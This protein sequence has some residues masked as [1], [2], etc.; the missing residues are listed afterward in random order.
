MSSSRQREAAFNAL[1]VPNSDPSYVVPDTRADERRPDNGRRV[2][3]CC[4][5]PSSATRRSRRDHVDRASGHD[6]CRCRNL[7]ALGIWPER[8]SRGSRS[9]RQSRR[10][11]PGAQRV[12]LDR[13][14]DARVLADLFYVAIVVTLL[15]V[16]SQLVKLK[17]S[18]QEQ[19]G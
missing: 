4:A 10:L 3:S 16:G 7:D 6:L 14:A 15:F 2:P 13:A 12:V 5:T 18:D 17:R 19:R 9:G 11:L 1:E 8:T